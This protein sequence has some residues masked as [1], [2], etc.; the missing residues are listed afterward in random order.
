MYFFK[1]HHYFVSNHIF[2]TYL[3]LSYR[4]YSHDI[5]IK[6]GTSEYLP[7][8]VSYVALIIFIDYLQ[9]QSLQHLL[10]G[11]MILYGLHVRNMQC[12]L[13][14]NKF[15]YLKHLNLLDKYAYFW[16]QATKYHNGQLSLSH[17]TATFIGV[18]P[19][20]FFRGIKKYTHHKYLLYNKQQLHTMRISIVYTN[21]IS[22]KLKS[23]NYIN[24]RS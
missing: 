8:M 10:R 4:L 9:I 18:V 23:C 14:L 2:K 6:R 21:I 13:H 16:S 1:I 12:T 11:T 7:C 19:Y 17:N 5:V 15:H 3:D 20:G 22:L 24:N